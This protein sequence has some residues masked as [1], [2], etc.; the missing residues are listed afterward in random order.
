MFTD[1]QVISALREWWNLDAG[2][3]MPWG[4]EADG[5]KGFREASMRDM[6]AALE[7]ASQYSQRGIVGGPTVAHPDRPTCKP[8]GSCCD[9][10]C[11]N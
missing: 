8:D 3:L 2:E 5:D 4:D 6:R 10:V 11:G 1:Q 7:A 9:F